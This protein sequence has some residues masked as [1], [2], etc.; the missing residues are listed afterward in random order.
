MDQ[1]LLCI[2]SWLFESN[3]TV[4]DIWE[5]YLFTFHEKLETERDRLFNDMGR[6]WNDSTG[7]NLGTKKVTQWWRNMIVSVF[8]PAIDLNIANTVEDISRGL[9]K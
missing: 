3:P 2:G 8:H 4:S 7:E 1:R 6:R 5:F 9:V